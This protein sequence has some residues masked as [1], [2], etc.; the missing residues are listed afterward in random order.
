MSD[1]F[2]DRMTTKEYNDYH[3]DL[4]GDEREDIKETKEEME[5]RMTKTTWQKFLCWL[6]K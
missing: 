3:R 4:F 2:L 1:D 6:N 5:R